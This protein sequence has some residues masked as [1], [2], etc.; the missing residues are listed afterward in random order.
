MFKDYEIEWI[1]V[2]GK[3]LGVIRPGNPITIEEALQQIK[4]EITM[5][6]EILS[7]GFV[8]RCTEHGKVL[9]KVFANLLKKLERS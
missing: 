6:D 8:E 4:R 7:E 9:K 1:E 3:R 5:K 2:N